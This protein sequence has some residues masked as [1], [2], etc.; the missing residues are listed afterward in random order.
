MLKILIADDHGI[1]RKGLKQILLEGFSV[2]HIEETDN[3]ENL[4]VKACMD[5]WDI[6]ISDLAMPGGGG[7]LALQKIKEQK[8]L[9]RILILSFYPEEQY[10]IPV[11]RAG[12]SGYLNKNAAPEELISAVRQILT[13]N[14]Y[15]RERIG[16]KPARPPHE[17]GEIRPHELLSERELHVFRLLAKGISVSEISASLSIGASTVSTYRSRILAKMN[18][19]INADLTRYALDN[20]MI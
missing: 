7:F 1:V 15:T 6:V 18:K 5:N 3:A 9:T 2:V 11:I 19:K 16:K 8:P 14:T 17:A 13:G 10:A 12:A 4:V 20:Q